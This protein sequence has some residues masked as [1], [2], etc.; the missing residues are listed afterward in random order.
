MKTLTTIYASVALLGILG[1]TGA[2]AQQAQNQCCQKGA[3]SGKM[4]ART[5]RMFNPQ[6]VET[7]RGEV[8][9]VQQATPAQGRGRGVHL[10]VKTDQGNIPVHLGPAWFIENQQIQIKPHDQ[11]EVK[12][13]RVTFQGQPALIAQQ[14]TVGDE[15]L[16]LRDATGRPAWAAWRRGGAGGQGSSMGGVGQ[17]G[18]MNQGGKGSSTQNQA[19]QNQ[20]EGAE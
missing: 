4:S 14:V 10:M 19:E 9:Q 18:T 7:I 6:T 13:S 5:G 16:Q 8:L 12:G 20:T 11:I 2:Y 17:S 1:G 15:V 3:T